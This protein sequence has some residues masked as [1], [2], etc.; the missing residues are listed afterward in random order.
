MAD[1]SDSA[2]V[3]RVIPAPPEAIFALIADPNRHRDIDGSGTV[4]AA[5]AVPSQL[6]L[7]STFGMNMR[8]GIPY[9]MVSTVIEFEPNRR[10]A[11][12]SRPAIGKRLAGGRIWRY[13][14]EPVDGGT[15]VRET[16]DISEEVI[17]AIVRPAREKTIENMTK[18]LERI[19]ELVTAQK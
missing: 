1:T 5:K 17:K 7:G 3:E 19:E 8:L 6:E 11:W 10:I 2:S 4:R 16:W 13:E 9:S 15:R 18:T 12:Q 14:L